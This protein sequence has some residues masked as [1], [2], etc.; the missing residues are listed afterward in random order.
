MTPLPRR[1]PWRASW[2]SSFRPALTLDAAAIARLC[3]RLQR[4]ELP[5]R[6]SWTRCLA[7]GPS[8]V[9]LLRRQALH[10]VQVGHGDSGPPLLRWDAVRPNRWRV[11]AVGLLQHDFI[12]SSL[13][14]WSRARTSHTR[15]QL[16]SI[17][18]G[19]TPL[20]FGVPDLDVPGTPV[21]LKQHFRPGL[22]TPL[23]RTCVLISGPTP[24]PVVSWIRGPCRQVC[25][26]LVPPR[27]RAPRAAGRWDGSRRPGA[28]L[29]VSAQMPRQPTRAPD[30]ASRTGSP[31][32]PGAR[33][34]WRTICLTG[35]G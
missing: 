14:C 3:A 19:R 23:E 31:C 35:Q 22:R 29:L 2:R 15:T 4:A 28:L 30:P 1:G 34:E 26:P 10:S 8:D 6:G 32:G 27:R 24:C 9:E 13:S 7:C 33:G 12:K 11:V 20:F 16:K 25:P 5:A 21:M 18:K 17:C